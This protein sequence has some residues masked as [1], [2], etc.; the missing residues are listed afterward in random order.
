MKLA[1]FDIDGTLTHTAGQSEDSYTRIFREE[2]GIDLSQIDWSRSRYSTDS[3]IMPWVFQ[4]TLGRDPQ[5]E[6]MDRLTAALLQGTKARLAS[7]EPEKMI[8][9]GA[10]RALERLAEDGWRV[11]IATGGW[12]D[13]A[14]LKLERAGIPIRD[15][16]VA[17]ADDA[18]GRSQIIALAVERSRAREGGNEFERVV[19]VGDAFWDLNAAGR[20]GF[21]F[22][23]RA[24]PD[25]RERLVHHGAQCILS[26]YADYGLLLEYLESAPV[27]ELRIKSLD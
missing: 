24:A 14:L 16:A 12:R 19:Y 10:P 7:Y 25:K 11:A 21:G 27:P 2:V 9:T 17:F 22:V 23:G 8:V 15:K 3:G 18:P 13:T 26:D 1:V 6:E 20:L 4:Q 5:P